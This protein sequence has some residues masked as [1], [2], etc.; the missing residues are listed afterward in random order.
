MQEEKEKKPTK[1]AKAEKAVKTEKPKK[2]HKSKPK[3]EPAPSKPESEKEPAATEQETPEKQ[4]GV[5]KQLKKAD[6]SRRSKR[7]DKLAKE[8]VPAED[9]KAVVYIGHLPYGFEETGLRKFFEQ[10]GTITRMKMPRSKKVCPHI[11]I[12]H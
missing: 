6:V 7:L 8:G 4:L 11:I 9:T 10:F 12:V 2:V 5:H 1:T 3:K